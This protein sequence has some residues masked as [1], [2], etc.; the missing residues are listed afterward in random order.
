M[1]VLA[2][3]SGGL[4]G[5]D[6]PKYQIGII[7][8]GSSWY[9]DRASEAFLAELKPLA[10]DRYEFAATRFDASGE[11]MA[12]SFRAALA[13]PEI[14]LV[15]AAGLVA[16]AYAVNL[17]E[18][19]R[20]KP[21]M[22]AALLFGDRSNGL[23]SSEGTSAVKNLTFISEPTRVYADLAL[24]KRLAGTSEI[25]VPLDAGFIE[26]SP[27]LNEAAEQLGESIGVSVRVVPL[28]SQSQSVLDVVP[29]RARAVY[30]P[31]LP[32]V[33]EGERISIYRA[34]ARRGAVT[35]SMLGEEEVKV[36]ALAGLASDTS[37]AVARRTAVN[38]HQLLQGGSTANL[39]VVLP[40][41][42][43]LLVNLTTAELTGW[44]PSY[45]ISLE[46]DFVNEPLPS[47]GHMTL[48]KA[49]EMATRFSAE[50]IIT[51]EDENI[52]A[53]NTRL[54]RSDLL[55]QVDS[56]YTHSRSKTNDG[57]ISTVVSPQDF[58]EHALGVEVSQVLYSDLVLSNL[59]AQKRTERATKLDTLST[60][61][62]AKQQAASAYF[63]YLEAE[64]LYKIEKENVRISS[65]NLQLAKLRID[66]GSA[67][68]S[69]VFRWEQALAR[70]RATLIQRDADRELALI[71]FNRILASPREARWR[72]EEI[73]LS[74]NEF[75]FLD[76]RLD[77]LLTNRE[78]VRRFRTF[79]R[80]YA[81]EN[82]PELMSFDHSL[83]AQGILL[84]QQRRSFFVPEIALVAGAET[85]SFE[86]DVIRRSEE[87]EVTLGIEFS[88]PLYTG[89]ARNAE[90]RQRQAVI[91][92]IEATR[93]QALQQLEANALSAFH[94]V[95]AAHP[96]IRLSR[97]SL[98]AAQKNYD[99]VL[100]KYS[101]GAS[102]ILDLLDAKDQLL[103]ESQQSASAVYDYLDAI[104]Q[105]QRSIAWFE[106]EK[107]PNERSE[108]LDLISAFMEGNVPLTHEPS[109][110][111]EFEAAEAILIARP[112][113][114]AEK[115]DPDPP[116]QQVSPKKRGLFDL[117]KKKDPSR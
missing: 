79:L 103:S 47:G 11:G 104:Y 72:F 24:L 116:E 96:N 22:A 69:E 73:T 99:S 44:S 60:E 48:T 27:G 4:F 84:R 75:Y 9:F 19:Q 83:S 78:E 50:T 94:A 109:T 14:D 55:P 100:D 36:G 20:T 32:Q 1:V 86:A 98:D 102:T 38:V 80:W 59:G 107:G 106:Q 34:L 101:Q 56:T 111:P 93:E 33:S 3:L 51:R 70:D 17:P 61:L 97:V 43:Q 2:G 15:Y 5:Q 25:F 62:D 67:E 30:V 108:L 113:P 81:V 77:R 68:P 85:N 12:E 114:A 52:E 37:S 92:Q 23:I 45:D 64:S 53:E 10:K 18:A 13:D 42:D 41:R 40:V 28:R 6:L 31:I 66:I 112:I 29:P 117:F 105:M 71:E 115:S 54:A 90:L 21:V 95:E 74:D 26:E 110:V 49:L 8:E 57:P 46:A 88:L 76:E 39:P 65:D 7:H 87:D 91:R 35:V 16:S 89:G 82:S 63:E 58:H